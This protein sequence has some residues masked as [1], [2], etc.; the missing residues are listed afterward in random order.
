[1]ASIQEP[2]KALSTYFLYLNENRERFV[3]ELGDKAKA[4]GGLAAVTSYAS[5]KYRSLSAEEKKVY[6]QKAVEAKAEYEK[7]LAE[8]KAQGGQVG[9]RRAEKRARK[10]GDASKKMKPADMP[11]RPAGGAYGCY[12]AEHRAAIQGS[13]P[14]GS[15]C[16]MVAKKAGEQ[17]SA[18]GPQDREKFEKQYQEKKAA[19]ELAMKEWKEKQGD[20]AEEAEDDE[21]GED[22]AEDA[23]DHKDVLEVPSPAKK[24]RVSAPTSKGKT[25]ASEKVLDEAKKEGLALKL[26]S[27]LDN[28]KMSGKDAGAVLEVLR[29]AGGKVVEAKK[30][31]LA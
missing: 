29:K 28:P 24:A 18:L 1:M 30:A 19:F 21:N 22:D 9:Q 16:T 14:A 5:E 7:K 11:K 10:A 27:L 17:W 8:F 6:E 13:L 3:K 26:K 23:D 15:P 12:V 2:K 25:E 4:K 20:A 31:L